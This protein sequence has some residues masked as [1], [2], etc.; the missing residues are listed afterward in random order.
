[1]IKIKK[2][3]F[4][5]IY[6]L[7]I[8]EIT[9][10]LV[11][12]SGKLEISHHPEFYMQ[13][14]FVSNN[15]WWTEENF[16]GAW[17]LK[18]SKTKQIKSCFN[19]VYESNEVGARDKSFKFNSTNDIILIGDSFAEGYGVNYENTSQKFIENLSGFN[20]LNFG[21]SKNF[22]PVQYFIIYDKF[23]KHF[24]H[25]K[26]IIYFLPDNDFGEN[27]FSNWKGSYRFRPY[28]K[29]INNNLY[30]TFI[31]D[32]SV[33]NY[34][35]FTKKIKVHLSKYFWSSNLFINLNYQYKI[36]RSNKKKINNNFSAYFD[37]N[38]DQQ[39]AA[40][41]FLEKIIDN[42]D[43]KVFLV[44]IPRLSDFKK[45]QTNPNLNNTYWNDF[46][47]KKDLDNKNFKFID[48]IKYKPANLN[49][50]FLNCDGHWSPEGNLWA[51]EII[52]K[53]LK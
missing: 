22:G 12:K 9:S 10:F 39:K 20:V 6:I 53:F 34:S 29:K 16:W 17:H 49:K 45:Y 14:N 33:K 31:P 41:F 38:L 1:M 21:V 52:S 4:I 42:T 19:V 15:N 18:K 51:A 11:F 36:Y 24:K 8:L 50:I 32:F 35:S 44:S 40:I 46:F 2:V 23:A 7:I 43:A 3:L 25:N 47:V 28:Y 37:A 5:F 26:I 13:K 27:D 30:E 48:L